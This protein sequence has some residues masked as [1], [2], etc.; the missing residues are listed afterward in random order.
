MGSDTPKDKVTV[1]SSNGKLRMEC[2]NE[3]WFMSLEDA[4]CKIE[5]WRI[6]FNQRRTI[7]RWAV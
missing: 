2:M 4:K 3:N 6:H 5:A 7:Q 1:E